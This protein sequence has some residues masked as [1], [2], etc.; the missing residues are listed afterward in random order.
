MRNDIRPTKFSEFNGQP[1]AVEQLRVPVV[2]AG[3]LKKPL[4]HVLISGPPG[5]G[6]TTLG[7]HV[8]ATELGSYSKAL[9]C[10]AIEKPEQLLPTIL[11]MKEGQLLFLDEIHRLPKQLCECLYT[12]ME[13]FQLSMVYGD[14][15]NEKV[16][17]I[18]L[19]PFTI[20]GATTREGMIPAPMLSRFKHSVKLDLYSDP[21]MEQVLRW[22]LPKVCSEAKFEA[23]SLKH[24]VAACHGT[25]R[26]ASKL[27]EACVDT[28]VTSDE[29]ED[30]YGL[31]GPEYEMGCE[32]IP[33][34]DQ[35]IQKTLVRLGI[36]PNGLNKTERDLLRRL[37]AA[38]GQT[39]GLSSMAAML[40]EEEETVE[41]AYEPWLLRA[42]YII[43]TPRGR[44]LAPAGSQAL[45]EADKGWT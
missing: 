7:R 43:R 18:D 8:L 4:G 35:S 10:A 42:G 36:T 6:K 40:D 15:G 3:R 26:H 1:A 29:Y 38:P 11:G 2:A 37:E 41:T 25:A 20:V 9:N 34:T 32:L 16:M 21:D 13:D 17:V 30:R 44:Q 28:F 31:G 19:P 45:R 5:L 22:T 24:L 23:T 12:V 14:K 33:V 27:L 39:L